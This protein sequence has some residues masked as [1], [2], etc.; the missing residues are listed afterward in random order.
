MYL[1][2]YID[3]VLVDLLVQAGSGQAQ[4]FGGLSDPSVY[5][6]ERF[7][8]DHGLKSSHLVFERPVSAWHGRHGSSRGQLRG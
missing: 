4:L 2:V 7:S 8:D 1:T 5:G 6:F 3:A